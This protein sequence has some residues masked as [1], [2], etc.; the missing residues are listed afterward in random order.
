MAPSAGSPLNNLLTLILDG[1]FVAEKR[2][3]EATVDRLNRDHNEIRSAVDDGFLL[4]G[5]YYRPRD[6]L[7]PS[8]AKKAPLDNRL[9]TEGNAFLKDTA[10][11]E[12]E[13][14]LIKQVLTHLLIPCRCE[15]DIRDALPDC[16]SAL[17]PREIHSL[18]RTNEEAWTIRNQER[19]LRQYRKVLPRI[20]FYSAA[21][22]IY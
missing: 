19:A 8:P 2:R 15:Q 14:Q 10:K 12:L 17:M 18:P 3:L 9:M 16:L 21:R 6:N 5:V 20:E 4:G 7:G 13:R 1:L 11:V 22:L